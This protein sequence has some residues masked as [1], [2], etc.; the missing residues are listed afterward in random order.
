[1]KGK[2][3]VVVS[4]KGEYTECDLSGDLVEEQAAALI[5]QRCFEE[6]LSFLWL[7]PSVAIG[8]K[9]IVSPGPPIPTWFFLS[10]SVELGLAHHHLCP[11]VE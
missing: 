3:N 2:V 1:M 4:E 7:P 11:R 6:K 5:T 8:T 10:I 9:V